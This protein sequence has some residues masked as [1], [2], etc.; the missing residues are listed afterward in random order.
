MAPR[1][2]QDVLDRIRSTTDWILRT[3][4][5]VILRCLGVLLKAVF[6]ADHKARHVDERA[7]K[8]EKKG[9]IIQRHLSGAAPKKQA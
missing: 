7:E 3:F 1:G 4:L 2:L 6:R 5:A 9:E 8:Q